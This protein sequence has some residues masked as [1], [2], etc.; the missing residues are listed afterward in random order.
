MSDGETLALAIGAIVLGLI[1][2]VI[3]GPYEES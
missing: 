2:I 1:A 3:A